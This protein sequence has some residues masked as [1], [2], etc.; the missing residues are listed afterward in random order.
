MGVFC[1]GILALSL[2]CL[3]AMIVELFV[4]DNYG[5]LFTVFC[6]VC[7]SLTTVAN[8]VKVKYDC[9]L[10][11]AVETYKFF[12]LAVSSIMFGISAHE[13]RLSAEILGMG[14]AY[15]VYRSK[16]SLPREIVYY[17]ILF[18][19]VVILLTAIMVIGSSQTMNR[20]D[21]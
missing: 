14:W 19:D 4:W 5:Y 9:S 8:Y 15:F 7:S 18:V 16:Q 17:L 12:C 11:F 10:F 13:A 6:L 2:F 20:D 3:Y 1:C 21:H